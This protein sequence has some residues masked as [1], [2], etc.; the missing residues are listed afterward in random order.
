M[1]LFAT[2]TETITDRHFE[3]AVGALGIERGDVLLVHSDL[4]VTGHL[5]LDCTRAVEVLTGVLSSAVGDEGVLMMPTFNYDF[6]HGVPFD[7]ATSPARTGGWG[8]RFLCM[9]G[10]V[11][12]C[13]PVH[14]MAVRDI[15]KRGF[16]DPW[17]DA[18]GENSAFAKLHNAHGKIIFWGIGIETCTFIHYVEQCYGV[19][20]RFA[21]EFRVGE[22]YCSMYCRD[23]SLGLDAGLDGLGARLTR[24]GQLLT[25]R[26]GGGT[27]SAVSADAVYDEATEMLNGDIYSL[28]KPE[29]TSA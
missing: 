18:Y 5:L 8:R 15:T 10:V 11:R 4:S 2:D 16:G 24:S 28:T 21:K 13:H 19:P 1:D 14:S 17:S 25:V 22:Q 23:L 9:D 6:C 7:P 12:A 26:I 27:I 3:V 29:R 20:Y